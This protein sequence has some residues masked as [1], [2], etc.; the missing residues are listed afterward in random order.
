L[1]EMDILSLGRIF[2]CW[3]RRCGSIIGGATHVDRS[4][5][6]DLDSRKWKTSA[7]FVGETPYRTW[8]DKR[9]FI[10][11]WDPNWGWSEGAYKGSEN[12]SRINCRT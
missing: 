9:R 11:A 8:T 7:R 4:R 12:P 2:R 1:A 6:F 10:G 3:W 5:S